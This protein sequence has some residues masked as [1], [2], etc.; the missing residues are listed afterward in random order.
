MKIQIDNQQKQ[1]KIDKRKIRS[2]VTKLMNLLDCANKEISITFVDDAAIQIIN[3]I[4][5]SKDR[6]TNVISFSLQEGE[7]GGINPELLG[8]VVISVDT[9]SRDAKKGHLTFDEEILFLIIHGLLHLLGYNHVNTSKANALK[10]KRKE[11]E[12]FQL[13]TKSDDV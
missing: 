11:N 5:L 3:K 1:I 13:L 12:L 7:F 6:P 9:A 10:M 2:E 4:Y 8:D